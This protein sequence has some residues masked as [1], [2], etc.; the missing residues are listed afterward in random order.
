M[1]LIEPHAPAVAPTRRD[2]G[3]TPVLIVSDEPSRVLA[4]LTDALAALHVESRVVAPRPWLLEDD[5][6][7]L[8]RA[9]AGDGFHELR[10]LEIR[11]R[12]VVNRPSA[13][14]IAHHAVLTDH[15][16]AADGVER[17]RSIGCFDA[18]AAVEAAFAIGFP[19][20]VR[21]AYARGGEGVVR[22]TT[23]DRLCDEVEALAARE[24]GR[25]AGFAVQQEVP[26]AT[27]IHVLVAEGQPVAAAG[28]V[29]PEVER[30]AVRAVAA[31]GGDV[32]SAHVLRR[33]DGRL[34]VLDVNGAP[35]IE[36]FGAAAW[37]RVAEVIAARCRALV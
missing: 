33:P 37:S 30:L 31:T 16:L 6:I 22:C 34:A 24:E 12:A 3:T 4:P 28:P 18:D 27:D 25:R 15:A 2:G 17:V 11:G 9:T 1:T 10:P 19:V 8:L 35:P 26:G 14:Q 23:A 5:A 21:P 32:M 29:T 20:R 13:L 7:L 36:R